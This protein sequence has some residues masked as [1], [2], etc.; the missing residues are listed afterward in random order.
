MGM[1]RCAAP[2]VG[3]IGVLEGKNSRVL[4]RQ[5]LLGVPRAAAPALQAP[6]LGKSHPRRH[7]LRRVHLA[8]TAPHARLLPAKD[9]I[10]ARKM[11]KIAGRA[12]K[13]EGECKELQHLEKAGREM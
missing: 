4:L 6:V 9:D 3:A 10:A 13:Q 8:Q 11:R 2:L 7:I 12:A 1:E 5:A